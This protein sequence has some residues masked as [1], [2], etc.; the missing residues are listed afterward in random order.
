MARRYSD[1]VSPGRALNK[2]SPRY[3]NPTWYNRM[4]AIARGVRDSYG[5]GNLYTAHD[6]VALAWLRRMRYVKP[7]CPTPPWNQVRLVML[8]E[9]YKG[10]LWSKNYP[11]D[12][13][14][15]DDP[16]ELD[17]EDTS[18]RSVVDVV[19]DREWLVQALSCL[20]GSQ[21]EVMLLSIQGISN[22]K[23]GAKLKL[24]GE[25]VGRIRDNA[26]A[27]MVRWAAR[28]ELNRGK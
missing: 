5:G 24:S 23:I 16:I 2:R 6:L 3:W 11:R 20:P 4:L 22:R 12:Y 25:R 9:L 1:R 28:R 13:S 26:L 8:D 14:D 27:K 19:A 18:Q 7:D 10:V 17:Q 15:P 21:R